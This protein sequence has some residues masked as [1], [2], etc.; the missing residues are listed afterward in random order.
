MPD[1]DLYLDTRLFALNI[2]V[3]HQADIHSVADFRE[4]QNLSEVLPCLVTSLNQL[5]CSIQVQ[6]AQGMVMQGT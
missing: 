3:C 6:V 1:L 5:S 2:E 4:G